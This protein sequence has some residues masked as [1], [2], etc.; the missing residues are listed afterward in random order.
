MRIGFL[1]LGILKELL[2]YETFCPL[3]LLTV[4]AFQLFSSLHKDSTFALFCRP[5][6]L[7]SL[8][9]ILYLNGEFSCLLLHVGIAFTFIHWLCYQSSLLV[10]LYVFFFCFALSTGSIFFS[11]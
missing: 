9:I 7:D 8:V 4:T 5:N 10:I 2:H 6:D 1:I 11:V 3:S